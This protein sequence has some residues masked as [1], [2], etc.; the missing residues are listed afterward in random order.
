MHAFFSSNRIASHSARVVQA[1]SYAILLLGSF[2]FLSG[3]VL[4]AEEVTPLKTLLVAESEG[5]LIDRQSE[6]LPHSTKAVNAKSNPE[7]AA[8]FWQS[9]H[10]SVDGVWISI[11]DLPNVSLDSKNAEYFARR[12]LGLLDMEGHRKLAHWC[13]SEGL[14]ER[15]RAHWYGVLDSDSSDLQARK[16][17]NFKRVESY[18][19][20]QQENEESIRKSKIL[21]DSLKKWMPKVREWVAA[22]EGQ[23]TKKRVKAIEQL[24][25]VNDPRVVAA[26][27]VAVGQVSSTSALHFLQAMKRFQT[28]EAC[29][30]LAGIAISDPSSPL[31]SAAIEALKE[32][33]MEFYVPALLDSMCTEYQLKE[34]SV[35]RRNGEFVLQLV[36]FRELRDRFEGSQVDK[37]LKVNNQANFVS[38]ENR[39]LDFESL[40]LWKSLSVMAKNYGENQVLASVVSA[41]SQRI[42]DDAKGDTEKANES[43]RRFQSN[44]A[45]VLRTVS[46]SN[47]L[48]HPQLWW[49]WWDEY[50]ES[51]NMGLKD[52]YKSYTEDRS[53]TITNPT[54]T[55]MLTN[56]RDYSTSC[57]PPRRCECLV[58]GTQIQTESG[59]KPVESIRIGDQVVSQDITSGEISL[60]PVLRTTI[61]PAA[62]TR[63]I[64]LANGES[65]RCTLGH[66]WWVV[67]RGWVM[68]KNL[69][70]AMAIRT[71]TGFATIESLKDAQAMETY[72]LVV[73]EDHTYFVGQSRLLSFDASELIPTFQKVPG[74]P[75]DALKQP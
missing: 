8:M 7:S 53:Y 10:L 66:P 13:K 75:A 37:V 49:K 36:Q 29:I 70:A 73:D 69:E 62:V 16:E 14:N 43:V 25:S 28:P 33:P 60:R 45:T 11:A 55:V 26:L 30:A 68:A 38:V 35:T 42:A 24:R 52:Q 34:Q 31:G 46:G 40:D 48:D 23:D 59:L 5:A 9:G 57:M 12:G 19:I 63:E 58:L 50:Q 54:Q 64:V 3:G 22:L 51:F 27:H 65:I 56:F 32:Y 6:L 4:Q 17:L 1:N 74:V 71:A 2:M 21:A 61:R 18:W 44:V 39:G 20:S 47:L 67:G 41:E 72:N 15:A